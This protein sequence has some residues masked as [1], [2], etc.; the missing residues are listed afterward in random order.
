MFEFNFAPSSS[1]SIVRF[2]HCLRSGLR[3]ARSIRAHGVESRPRREASSHFHFCRRNYKFESYPARLGRDSRRLCV[4]VQAARLSVS[5]NLRQTLAHQYAV[6]IRLPPLRTFA[7]PSLSRP[8]PSQE[9]FE[10]L[11]WASHCTRKSLPLD[12]SHFL[13]VFRFYIFQYGV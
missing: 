6:G 9:T 11:K 8:H 7:L 10:G 5:H 12:L 3:S 13:Q 4:R 2:T 1:V